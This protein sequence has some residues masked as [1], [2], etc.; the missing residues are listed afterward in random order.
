[1]EERTITITF[2][3]DTPKKPT[4]TDASGFHGKGCAAVTKAFA[5]ALG[6]T[7][8]ATDKPEMFLPDNG[9][10]NALVNA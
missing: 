3:L 2:P 4:T 7:I 10:S 6:T 1:M 9:N 5:G 8:S